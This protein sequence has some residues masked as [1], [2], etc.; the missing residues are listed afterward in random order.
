MNPVEGPMENQK[1]HRIRNY[2]SKFSHSARE[3]K[4]LTVDQALERLG[5]DRAALK[6]VYAAMYQDASETCNNIPGSCYDDIAVMAIESR[7]KDAATH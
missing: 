1:H 3:A 4:R 7:T 5:S 2:P 6:L